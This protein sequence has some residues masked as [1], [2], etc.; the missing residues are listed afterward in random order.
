MKV[1]ELQLSISQTNLVNN[2]DKMCKAELEVLHNNIINYKTSI[3]KY[4]YWKYKFGND[5]IKI[6]QEQYD[7][8]TCNKKYNIRIIA[9]AG[10][11]KTTTILCRIKYL[12]DHGVN[13]SRIILC[14]FNVEAAKSMKKK[15]VELFNFMPKIVVGT[16]DSISCKFYNMYFKKSYFIS[17]SEYSLELLKYLKSSEGYNI[18]NNYDY[19]FFD[20]F[21]DA[22][23]TQYNLLKEF[24]KNGTKV[25]VIGDDSQNIYQFR[26]SHV[27]YIIEF[28]KYINN[29]KTFKILHNYRSTP[30]IINMANKSI[31]FNVNQIK[32]DMI[33]TKSTIYIKPH[34][35]HYKNSYAE[36]L[37]VIEKILELKGQYSLE[38]IAIIS[39]T[40]YFLKNAEVKIEKHNKINNNNKINYV[41]LLS[42]QAIV[43]SKKDHITLT[44]IHKSKGLEWQIVFLIGCDDNNL[45]TSSEK[46][47]LEEERRL[48]YVAVTR[49]K[50]YLYISFSNK[51]GFGTAKIS[52][53][54]QE[55]DRSYYEFENY[56]LK[57]YSLATITKEIKEESLFKIIRCFNDI[58]LTYLRAQKFIPEITINS[59][60]LHPNTPIDKKILDNSWLNDFSE[61]IKCYIKRYIGC[62]N[63]KSQGLYDYYAVHVIYMILVT[64]DEESIFKK[65]IKNGLNLLQNDV[66]ENIKNQMLNISIDLGININDINVTSIK[67]LPTKMVSIFKKSYENYSN[68]NLNNDDILKDIY[69]ISLCS[70]V[71]TGR[72][73]LLYNVEAPIIFIENIKLIN[74]NIKKYINTFITSE[75]NVI[76]NLIIKNKKRSLTCEINLVTDNKIVLYKCSIDDNFKLEWLLELMGAYCLYLKYNKESNIKTLDIYN[77]IRGTVHTFNVSEITTLENNKMFLKF[78]CMVR[79]KQKVDHIATKKFINNIEL[80]DIGEI[81]EKNKWLT[82]S[83]INT[84]MTMPNN[85]I[86]TLYK[87]MLLEYYNSYKRITSNINAMYQI[88]TTFDFKYMIFDTETNGLPIMINFNKFPLYSDINAYKTARLIQQSWG[89]YD[90]KDNLLEMHNY[91]VKPDG[92]NITNS[93]IHGITFEMA[94]NGYNID[95][96]LEKFITSLTNVD[97]IICHNTNFDINIIKSELYRINKNAVNIFDNKKII[98]TLLQANI[99]KLNGLI[100]NAKLGTIYEYFFGEP[101]NNAHNAEYD[102]LNTGKVFSKMRQYGMIIF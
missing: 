61:F 99:M 36:I 22:N 70:S 65:Y 33:S 6:N 30:E 47:I 51:P 44:T 18:L 38:N 27:K 89:I 16:I 35:K 80:I 94:N 39:R 23:E 12:I 84:Y 21:Q 32:K 100:K 4:D 101:I 85:N 28:D 75:T 46:T 58:D 37:G 48:F 98:C 66:I 74:E 79:N 81:L 14:A 1:S 63:K 78:I 60:I 24:Y 13:P 95:I 41:S 7:I 52:R 9:A 57:Y 31:S 76:T 19:F 91:Y 34:V 2:I 53:F 93:H 59:S 54:I 69:N 71:Y 77:P 11:G 90:S 25:V 15:I 49:A 97:Y 62:I 45:P 42:D 5:E 55:L 72:K 102:V 20:E 68:E 73:R 64:K 87:K 82:M 56:D 8:V 10:S 40:T 17:V 96:V 88:S 83:Y 3:K 92:F 67:Q 43:T 26:G 86:K 29:L 50:I